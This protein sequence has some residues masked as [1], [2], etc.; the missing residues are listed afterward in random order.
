[1]HPWRSI[2]LL[3]ACAGALGL[4]GV[5]LGGSS[6]EH[7]AAFFALCVADLL[8]AAV[9]LRAHGRA[10][11]RWL[12][13]VALVALALAGA[14]AGTGDVPAEMFPLFFIVIAVWVGLAL[15][16]RASFLLAPAYA[17]AYGIPLI[18]TDSSDNAAGS[19]VTV[20]ALLVLVGLVIAGTI[21]RLDQARAR[22]ALLATEDP[23]TGLLNRRALNVRMEEELARARR[24]RRPLAA[25]VLDLDRFKQVNDRH[26]HVAGDAVLEA[27]GRRLRA[28]VRASDTA[29][30]SGGDEMIVLLPE[31]TAEEA[32]HAARRVL[33]SLGAAPVALPDGT[34]VPLSASVGSAAIDGDQLDAGSGDDLLRAADQALYAAKSAGGRRVRTAPA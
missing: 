23:L 12:W 2:A 1:M 19:I 20:T 15:P 5:V 33:D 8:V 3:F 25:L 4:I 31:T 28:A 10:S 21:R 34:S 18:T 30:R 7:R 27:C 13:V 14:F 32:E 16:W 26:G 17:A 11:D 9:C 24:Y 6:V 22:L 29:A